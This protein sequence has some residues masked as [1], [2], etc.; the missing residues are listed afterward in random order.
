MTMTMNKHFPGI[1]CVCC[2]SSDFECGCDGADWTPVEVYELRDELKELKKLVNEL[3]G[4]FEEVEESDS[5]IPFHPNTIT[6]CRVET[7]MRL[8]K[9]LPA[10]KDLCNE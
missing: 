9:L 8:L 7:N 4:I 10:I 3:L 6:T 1:G 5:G 2:A